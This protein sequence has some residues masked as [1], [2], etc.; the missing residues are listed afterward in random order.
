MSFLS[1]VPII[2][3]LVADADEAQAID[4]PPVEV[5]NV[6]TD[7]EKRARCL[8]HL[9]KANHVN[10]SIVYHNLQFDNHAAHILCSS[11]LFGAS[12]NQLHSIYET[13]SK[14]LEP[15]KDSPAEVI[16]EDWQE[17]LGDKRYQRAYVD[18]FEDG[19]ALQFNYDWKTVM[20]HY[21]LKGD[22]PLVHGLIGGLGHPL[23]HLGYAYEMN[24]KEIAIEALALSCVQYNY[25]HK[26]LDEKKYTKPSPFSSASPIDI[27]DKIASDS[28]F[29][30][31]FKTPGF[32]NID[33]LFGKHE[34][35]ILEY[36][37]A[38]TLEDPVRQFEQSQEAAVALL[39]ATVR[40]GTHAYN[41]FTVHLLTTSH[42]VRILLPVLPA[43]F[44]V[45][46]VREW[47][48]LTAA[49]YIAMGRPRIDPDNV[50]PVT[51]GRGWAHVEHEALNSQHAS[52]AHYV[53]AIRAMKEAARTWGDVHER[54]LAAAVTFVD[55]F[56]GWVFD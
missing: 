45:A 41:F 28:R 17:F 25:L 5:H 56:Q 32:D 47:W 48:L 24:S 14:E 23:I 26:Y 43:K 6:E 4:I 40:P 54:Y 38:W 10:H 18:F 20:E 7:P 36:W 34:D 2:G 22:Q 44:H 8:K 16:E 11:Y 3:R 29:D 15:W 46:L 39:V 27:L 12:E 9:L 19:L 13:V 30:G 51:Q 31:L 49:V 37:N 33:L 52:D 21:L 53:K 50:Q 1:Y 55:N 35:L 42:A